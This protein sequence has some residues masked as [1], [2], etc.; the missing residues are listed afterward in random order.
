MTVTMTKGGG[1][2]WGR[3]GDLREFVFDDQDD[4]SDRNAE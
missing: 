4:D 2:G 1:G 3:R